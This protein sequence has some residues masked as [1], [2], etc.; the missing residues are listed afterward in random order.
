ME[1]AS[2]SEIQ[3]LTSKLERANDAICANE[4][5]VERLNMRVDDLTENNRMILEDQQRV[6]EELRQS[7]KMLEVS[8]GT[9]RKLNI[10]QCLGEVAGRLFI[11]ELPSPS[12]AFVKFLIGLKAGFVRMWCSTVFPRIP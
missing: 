3:H 10:K 5:E 8:G 9:V 11:P 4:L 2:R 7:K 12:R 1:L 6:Q